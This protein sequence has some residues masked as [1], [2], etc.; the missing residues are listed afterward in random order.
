SGICH[1]P[2]RGRC[3]TCLRQEREDRRTEHEGGL[4]GVQPSPTSWRKGS[5][6]T[7]PRRRHQQWRRRLRRLLSSAAPQGADARWRVGEMRGRSETENARVGKMLDPPSV[8]YLK[9]CGW[10]C[11]WLCEALWYYVHNRLRPWKE[12]YQGASPDLTSH[13]RSGLAPC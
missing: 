6:W 8:P 13:V 12:R 3:R 10:L 7:P 9:L 5:C 1:K 11:N 4:G 2:C